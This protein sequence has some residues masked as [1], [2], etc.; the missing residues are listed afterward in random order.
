MQQLRLQRLMIQMIGRPPVYQ[1]RKHCQ[2]R[3]VNK[4]WHVRD[5]GSSN[6]TRLNGASA[7][8]VG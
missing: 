6:G 7:P 8:I 1:L 3:F 2:L 4:V 5:L